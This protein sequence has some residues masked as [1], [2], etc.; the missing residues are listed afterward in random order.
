L[1]GQVE[2]HWIALSQPGDARLV[3]LPDARG[4]RR[5]SIWLG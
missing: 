5:R 1:Q 3:G 4:A 2:A